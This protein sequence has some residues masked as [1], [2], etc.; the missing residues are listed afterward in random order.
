MKANT[1]ILL[2]FLLALALSLVASESKV[3][4][5]LESRELSRRPHIQE[6]YSD[7][8]IRTL[9]GIWDLETDTQ[10]AKFNDGDDFG[11]FLDFDLD[12]RR[13]L[14]RQQRYNGRYW[15]IIEVRNK[16]GD[17]LFSKEDRVS[18]EPEAF[19]VENGKY[20][21]KRT[22]DPDTLELTLELYQ[23]DTGALIWKHTPGGSPRWRL[24]NDS[25]S[26]IELVS[27]RSENSFHTAI[28]YHTITGQEVSRHD[29]RSLSISRGTD[30]LA[31]FNSPVAVVGGQT[32]SL[33][34]HDSSKALSVLNGNSW[35]IAFYASSPTISSDANTILLHN[36]DSTRGELAWAVFDAR[37]GQRLATSGELQA[38]AY[39]FLRTQDPALSANGKLV[40]HVVDYGKI[41]IWDLQTKSRIRELSYTNVPFETLVPSAD[42][43]YLLALALSGANDD[44]MVLIDTE[45]NLP[46][47]SKL[48]RDPDI[49][50]P[51]SGGFGLVVGFTRTL[52]LPSSRNRFYFSTVQGFEAFDLLSG[53]K[54]EDGSAF[55][56]KAIVAR[57][58]ASEQ[59]W[60]TVY[61]TGRVRIEND[62]VSIPNRWIQLPNTSGV[63]YAAID[64]Q[65]GSVAFQRDRAF[66][67]TH[68]FDQREDQWIGD[69]SLGI[70]PISLHHGGKWLAALYRGIYDLETEQWL[71]LESDLYANSAVDPN[72]KRLAQ[73]LYAPEAIVVDDFDDAESTLEIPR[74]DEYSSIRAIAFSNDGLQLYALV[75]ATIETF[76][77]QCVFV[78]DLESKAISQRHPVYSELGDYDFT[79][80]T[81]HASENQV[82]LG[83][84]RGN[85][86]SLDL[87]TGDLSLPVFLD[88]IYTAD[89]DNGI[90]DLSPSNSQGAFRFTD[91]YGHL[92]QLEQTSASPITAKLK[93]SKASASE[94]LFDKRPDRIYWIESS[95][96]LHNWSTHPDSSFISNWFDSRSSGFFKVYES[97]PTE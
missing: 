32:G 28:V 59:S 60:I 10:L 97:A 54:V 78:I 91:E 19:F 42:D 89:W 9:N 67:I 21:L 45:T 36:Y 69:L 68:P 49:F 2:L 82:Q 4:Y 57:Y 24:S 77:G 66:Y 38:E 13:S 39:P 34:F 22:N 52:K 53:E 47:Y 86:K 44:F 40:Y 71:P 26:F 37:N 70:H 43:R 56:G 41:E 80:M 30:Y 23:I 74:N 75:H 18:H 17:L 6:I 83:R 8:I 20:L 88:P 7:T 27:E 92:Y 58:V 65:S 25:L 62:S 64:S 35:G 1:P 11:T 90:F 94:L 73:Y 12:S 61:E 63:E 46:V 3:A 33:L 79:Q 29:V 87:A 5:T 55:A 96:D 50:N 72:N 85:T 76:T 51:P 16:G 81:V 31:S 93:P 84:R 48:K 15:F 95:P 14:Q